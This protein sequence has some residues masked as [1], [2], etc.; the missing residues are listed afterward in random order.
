MRMSSLTNLVLA[1][2]EYS[3][4]V[5]E[6]HSFPNVSNLVVLI[7][8]DNIAIIPAMIWKCPNL[9]SVFI[10]IDYCVHSPDCQTGIPPLPRRHSLHGGVDGRS[11][12]ITGRTRDVC[13]I[14][15]S[16]ESAFLASLRVLFLNTEMKGF[17]R[18]L[19]L[20]LPAVEVLSYP[21]TRIC[22]LSTAGNV[23]YLTIRIASLSHNLDIMIA[24]L[25]L[26]P[27]MCTLHNLHLVVPGEVVQAKG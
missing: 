25:L 16:L 24:S 6:W 7:R 27:S 8:Q 10:T 21:Q 20:C 12:A 11:F 2:L 5:T 23:R 18:N 14:L 15:R 13:L 17:T 26:L 19:F 22:D 1:R 4:A 3:L 9:S